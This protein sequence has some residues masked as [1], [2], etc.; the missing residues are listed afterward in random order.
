MNF[1]QK[2]FFTKKTLIVSIT[3]IIIIISL[4]IITFPFINSFIALKRVQAHNNTD[5]IDIKYTLSNY[6]E[7]NENAID[8][9]TVTDR[10][11]RNKILQAVKSMKI[12]NTDPWDK[13]NSYGGGGVSIFLTLTYPDNTTL[14]FES[15]LQHSRYT[16]TTPDGTVFKESCTFDADTL[17]SFVI[18]HYVI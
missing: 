13:L 3:I 12:S 4:I 10:H 7:V 15:N 2:R 16:L 6:S 9:G 14:L 1:S 18:A 8:N 17:L 11:E 5:N